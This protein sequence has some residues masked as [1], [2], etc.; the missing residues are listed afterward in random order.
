MDTSS[1][2]YPGPVVR[3]CREV[4]EAPYAAHAYVGL[5]GLDPQDTVRLHTMLGEG[6]PYEAFTSLCEVLGVPAS[7]MAQWLQ[8][9][10]RTVAR[11]RDTRRFEPSESDRILRMTRLVGLTLQLFEGDLRAARSWLETPLSGLAG[12][13][14][15]DFASTDVG[16]REVEQLIGRLEHGIPL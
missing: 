3:F 6:L 15:L 11:R 9:P 8:I 1:F 10:Q 5:L 13:T 16:A 12:S 4:A 2:T 7:R 14:P